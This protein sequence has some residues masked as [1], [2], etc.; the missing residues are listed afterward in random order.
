MADDKLSKC[1]GCGKGGDG[2][3]TC[4]ACK[5]VK[6]CNA[7]CQK[8]H[9][10]NHKKECK[11]R[12]AELHDEALFKQPPP[13]D[14]CPICLLP[15]PDAHETVYHSCCG[16]KVCHGCILAMIV[17]SKRGGGANV[18]AF[19]RAPKV[20]D[21]EDVERIKKRIEL[22]DAG[23]FGALAGRYRNG[24]GV[25]QD[26]RKATELLIRAGELGDANALYN[27]ADCYTEGRGVGR[28]LKRANHYYELAAEGGNVLAR[29][30]LGCEEGRRVSRHNLAVMMR[31]GDDE[32]CLMKRDRAFKHFVIAAK[33][34]YEPSLELLKK[35][36]M[37]GEVT[38]DVYEMALRG[39]HHFVNE[40]KSEQRELASTWR[41]YQGLGEDGSTTN[42]S[43]EEKNDLGEKLKQMMLGKF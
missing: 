39:Y 11:R 21:G 26:N 37:R 36:F 2:L 25:P 4:T 16:K 35:G 6:Y 12:A 9:R 43:V 28:D 10:P 8:A 33:A 20:T 38:K 32:G 13:D 3:K 1:A 31:D 23:A 29:H 34:G 30:N 18:C 42:I 17:E 22:N 27:V 19:C 14:E 40:R 7:T 15:L 24:R 41:A 5:M